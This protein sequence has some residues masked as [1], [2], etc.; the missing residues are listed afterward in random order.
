MINRNNIEYELE[1]IAKSAQVT[2]YEITIKVRS[3]AMARDS[4][5]TITVNGDTIHSGDLADGEHELL[6][7]L[8]VQPNKVIELRAHTA[9]HRHGKRLQIIG[10]NVNG[11]DVFK[12][13]LWVMDEQKFTHADGRVEICNNG[14]YHNGT[15]GIDLP[16]PLLP[17]L[18]Q[19]S[20]ARSK[21]SFDHLLLDTSSDEYR[22]LLDKFFR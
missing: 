9:S 11:V 10:L 3:V 7:Q 5:L 12:T 19:G 15:W 13:N 21:L 1:E 6:G 22:L 2:D 16:T 17:W 8:N 14:L 4:D 20:I 18:R